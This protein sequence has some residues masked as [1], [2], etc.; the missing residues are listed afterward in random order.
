MDQLK[1]RFLEG[2]PLGLPL[3]DIHGHIGGFSRDYPI[4]GGQLEELLQEMR[5]IGVRRC[6]V[7]PIGVY[8]TEFPF[9]NDKV[10]AACKK[11]PDY[12][13]GLSLVNLNYSE[14]EIIKELE[15][16]RQSGLVGAKLIAAYQGAKSDAGQIEAV[17]EYAHHYGLIV[18]NHGWPGLE[19]LRKIA[20]SYPK[21]QYICGHLWL[22]AATVVNEC[23]NVWM[24]TCAFL[25]PGALSQA[26]ATMRTDRLCW[27][28]DLSDLHWGFTLGPILLSSLSLEVKKKIISANTRSLFRKA[29][30]EK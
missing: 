25:S 5:R 20:C 13:S 24:C 7:F 17:C 16:C 8:G 30:L 26:V 21:G 10:I 6:L 2:K 14:K 1:K 28:S 27:G 9:Q 23:D 3:Y 4:F 18:L 19:F 11:Y 12:F 22:E 29:G 15:R